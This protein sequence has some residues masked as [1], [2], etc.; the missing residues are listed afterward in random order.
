MRFFLGLLAGLAIAIIIACGAAYFAFGDIRKADIHFDGAASGPHETK[1]YEL[2]DFDRIEFAGVYDAQVKVGGDFSISVSGSQSEMA[3]SD[4]RV[5]NG[6]LVLDRAESDKDRHGVRNRRGLKA[7]ITLPALN[8]VEASGVADVDVTGVAADSFSASLAGVGSVNVEGTCGT[9]KARLSGVG[10]LDTQELLCKSVDV[11]VTGVGDADVYASESVN[12]S[13]GGVG[14]ISVDGSPPN[15]VKSAS[16][17][18]NIR[19][20]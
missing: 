12:A 20:K 10:D 6:V 9:L 2:R 15:V 5:E 1:T 17:L 11:A 4:I 13:I 3:L 18:S 19:I 16:M 8:G 14:S 7:E